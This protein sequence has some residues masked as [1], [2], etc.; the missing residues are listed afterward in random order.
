MGIKNLVDDLYFD[1]V[2]GSH[3]ELFS[4]KK[5]IAEG[6]YGIIEYNENFVRINLIKG[7]IQIFGNNLEIF[8]MVSDTI[9]VKGIIENIEFV[10][11]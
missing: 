4:N 8:N 9:T 10:G 5:L 7:E 11:V 1:G 3:I 6:C 2:V